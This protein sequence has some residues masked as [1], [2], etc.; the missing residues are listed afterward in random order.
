MS[1]NPIKATDAEIVFFSADKSG[2]ASIPEP[3]YMPHLVVKGDVEYL[4]IRLLKAYDDAEL[5][6]PARWSL[7]LLYYPQVDYSKLKEGIQFDVREGPRVVGEG[8]II[9]G[10]YNMNI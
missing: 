10:Q 5:N 7:H 6:R 9:S 3:G 4:G 1:R 2:R 8:R